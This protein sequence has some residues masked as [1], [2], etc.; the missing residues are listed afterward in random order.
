MKP[1]RI[2]LGLQGLVHWRQPSTANQVI[3]RQIGLANFTSAS[4]LLR[5][6]LVLAKRLEMPLDLHLQGSTLKVR[7]PCAP[8]TEL[9]ERHLS[10][11]RAIE[12]LAAEVEQRAPRHG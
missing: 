2:Q 7:L 8:E 4:D 12:S 1:E 9:T 3:S 11:A 6:S 5:K 10:L